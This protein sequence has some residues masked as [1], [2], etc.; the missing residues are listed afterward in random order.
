[1]AVS[2]APVRSNEPAAYTVRVDGKA[3]QV[4]VAPSGAITDI[5]HTHTGGDEAVPQSASVAAG[6]TLNSPLSGN[7]FKVAVNPGD[8]VAAGDVVI[9]MEAMKM[10][11]EIRA[12][13]DGEVVDVFVKT[14]DSV[15]A[16]DPMISFA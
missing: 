13:K 16:G 1:P 14:G 11:T 8:Q 5:K 4:E 12:P 15:H 9:I 6:E 10:E 3:Y 2:S 7:I